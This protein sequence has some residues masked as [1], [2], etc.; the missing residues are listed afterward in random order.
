MEALNPVS[1]GQTF[2]ARHANSGMVSDDRR[3]S[4]RQTPTDIDAIALNEQPDWID[5]LAAVHESIEAVYIREPDAI[6]F[7]TLVL[8]VSDGDEP[9]YRIELTGGG[10]QYPASCPPQCVITARNWLQ[11]NVDPVEFKAWWRAQK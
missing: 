10:W 2:F 7:P 11:R 9:W 3:G 8:A 6:P 1:C 5:D 4:G